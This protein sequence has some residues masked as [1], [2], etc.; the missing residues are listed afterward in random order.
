MLKVAK[1]K[2]MCKRAGT[3]LMVSVLLS[4]CS[5]MS[6]Y[7]P[8]NNREEGPEKGLFSGSQGEFVIFR[9]KSST[10]V[11]TGE[12]EEESPKN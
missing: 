4:G 7:E 12:L 5:C 1:I 10:E 3:V 2:T 9:D 6:A 11:D 8:R